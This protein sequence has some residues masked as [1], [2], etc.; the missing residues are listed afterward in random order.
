MYADWVCV[1][2]MW[3]TTQ[4][5]DCTYIECHF[6]VFRLWMEC[7]RFGS[8]SVSDDRRCRR[9]CRFCLPILLST[10][11]LCR[12][13]TSHTHT[14]WLACIHAFYL[15]VQLSHFPMHVIFAICQETMCGARTAQQQQCYNAKTDGRCRQCIKSLFRLPFVY[16]SLSLT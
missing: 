13:H 9:R 10:V 4:R 11:W 2:H 14:H 15:S 3:K 16:T 6:I 8:F 12:R 5:V 7:I 1:L